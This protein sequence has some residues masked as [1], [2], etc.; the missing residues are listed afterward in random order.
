MTRKED[1]P[2]GRTL[3]LGAADPDPSTLRN[4][5]LIADGCIRPVGSGGPENQAVATERR[6]RRRASSQAWMT[7]STPP[8]AAFV[9]G[10]GSRRRHD[11]V[12]DLRHV[13]IRGCGSLVLGASTLTRVHVRRVPV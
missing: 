13:A 12:L 9:A 7:N 11:D 6:W 1:R 5:G 4:W 3:A 10:I 2:L 8:V